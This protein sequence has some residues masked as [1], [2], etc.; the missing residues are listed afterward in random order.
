MSLIDTYC[1]EVDYMI[2]TEGLNDETW[3]DIKECIRTI[4]L[5]PNPTIEQL[6]RIRALDQQ[7]LEYE[8]ASFE[9]TGIEPNVQPLDT[10]EIL[11]E[12]LRELRDA[13]YI[14]Q[15]TLD[16]LA[17][18]NETIDRCTSKT[19]KINNDLSLANKLTSKMKAWWRG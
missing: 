17:T 16:Q 11:R 13:E 5:Q 18:Q 3:R 4:K 15:D 10:I 12:S 2:A 7:V 6:Q 19:Q 9:A 8:R 1:D 14:A